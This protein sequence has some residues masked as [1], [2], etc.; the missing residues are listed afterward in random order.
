LFVVA[1]GF[2]PNAI[3]QQMASVC[4][5]TYFVVGPKIADCSEAAPIATGG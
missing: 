1:V 3:E 2:G 5:R 4:S